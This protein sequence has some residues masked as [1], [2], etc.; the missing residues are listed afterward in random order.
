MNAEERPSPEE[1]LKAVQHEERQINK[2]RLKIF[3][4]M[5][6]GV[7][8]TYAMLSSAQE[9]SRSG[10]DIVVGTVDTHGRQE[11]A[12]LLKG[13]EIIPKKGILYKDKEILEMDLEAILNRQPDI[14]IVDEL[15]HN[16]TPGSHNAKRW[17][18][19]ID[20]LDSGISVYTTL[21][22]QHIESLNDIVKGITA[23][24]VRE[25]V[26]D[27]LIERAT[28]IQL[29]DL[30][31]DEL[32][33]R[34]QEGKVYLGDQSQ[35]AALNF[36]Q[37]DRLTALRE[38]VLRYAADKV[39]SDLRR[40]IP[41]KEG[42]IEWKPREKFLVAI[43][44]NPHSQKLIRTARRLAYAVDAPWIAVHVDAGQDLSEKENDQLAKNL[45]LAR[46][47]GAEIVTISEPS[48]T[49]GIK[50]VAYLRGITQI[51]VGRSPYKPLLSR[52]RGGTLLDRLASE[53]KDVDIH[54]IRQEK[55]SVS[56]RKG[57]RPFTFHRKL[58]DYLLVFFCVC[59]LTAVNWS[60]LAFIGYKT[61]GAIFLLGILS[62]SLYF[63]KGPILF[64]SLLYA[65]IW[66]LFFVPPSGKLGVTET[67]DIALLILYFLT[68]LTVGIL[69]DRE[70][71]HKA[72]RA[73]GEQTTTALYEIVRTLAGNQSTD[74][75]LAYIKDQ[76][77]RSVS[78]T[79][80]FLIKK[81]DNGLTLSDPENLL[82]SEK[83][84]SS[85][86]WSFE[87][88]KEAG[89][90]TDTLPS[91]KN[92]NIPLKGLHEVVGLLVFRPKIGRFLTEEEKNFL[93]TVCQQVANYL[94]RSFTIE[95]ASQNEQMQQV[96]K[97]HQIILDRLSQAFEQPMLMIRNNLYKLKNKLKAAD[98]I[99]HF[100]EVAEIESSLE[101]FI[102]IMTNI[103]AMANLSTGLAPLKLGRY[104]IRDLLEE[105]CDNAKSIAKGRPIKVALHGN[106]PS[107]T[108]DYYLIHILVYNLILN[109]V[110][111]SPPNSAIEVEAK[112]SDGVLLLSVTDQGKGIPEDQ[113]DA[114]FDKFY[115]LSDETPGI[116][117]GL[118]VAKTIAG[119]HGGS[120]KAENIPSGGAKFT[121]SLPIK[122]AVKQ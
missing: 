73:K 90:S 94:E 15:A 69:V 113:L 114:I 45:A 54:A 99:E 84:K 57:W 112:R 47:L 27:L 18:D 86:I 9:L 30:T 1:L 10:V 20:I 37:K 17:Q 93:R 97:V 46:D 107:I 116:G 111:H 79:Y 117:L 78:G 51:I 102:K 76:L 62:L 75:I 41:V 96:E 21:N 64:A 4:G 38:I 49:E 3:L 48:I 109:A 22:V 43:S 25:T 50:K 82:S 6:A 121:L 95:K 103:S 34:L 91:A 23:F 72:M 83:E 115:R 60:L 7:G 39:D 87:N 61:V 12:Q 100:K 14:V 24:S 42:V 55:Y 40:M 52:L 11:T 104:H 29:V 122:E 110:E 74:E 13:L 44:H 101:I 59:L 58:S 31:P 120:L 35:I 33:V 106:L 68:A 108:F 19:V 88:G 70:R 63:K 89:W 65:L 26:P 32:L 98:K 118:A 36:F 8:K 53:C 119:I 67:E 2:G 28:S 85:A 66:G 77:N 71:E 56:Y 105:C 81:I 80:E 92:L 16:N 5:A